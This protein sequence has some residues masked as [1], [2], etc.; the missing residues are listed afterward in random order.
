[1]KFVIGNGQKYMI[2]INDER[3]EFILTDS[4]GE[5][6]IIGTRCA[7]NELLKM[8]Q[9]SSKGILSF[10][11]VIERRQI[12]FFSLSEERKGGREKGRDTSL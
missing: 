4:N 5:T 12:H 1:M 10:K 7:E 9:N 8:Q 3:A 11:P 2:N 6:Y